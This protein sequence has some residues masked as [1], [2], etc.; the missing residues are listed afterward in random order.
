MHNWNWKSC[1]H[2]FF[3]T[4]VR[5]RFIAWVPLHHVTSFKDLSHAY[6]AQGGLSYPWLR[7][8]QW[9]NC[10]P[11]PFVSSW[12][13]SCNVHIRLFSNDS[14]FSMIWELQREKTMNRNCTPDPISVD[15]ELAQGQSWMRIKAA[16]KPARLVS[17]MFCQIVP[18]SDPPPVPCSITGY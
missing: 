14:S 8:T 17:T 9:P 13:E 15:L 10:P 18:V 2:W 4:Y 11:Q 5:V 12:G 7:E 3:Y 1:L 16:A 6:S